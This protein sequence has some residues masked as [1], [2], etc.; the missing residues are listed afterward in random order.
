MSDI[1]DRDVYRTGGKKSL[2]YETCNGYSSAHPNT[3]IRIGEDVKEVFPTLLALI[4]TL[5]I[6]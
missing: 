6:T 3:L 4:P 2:F 5:T 1:H